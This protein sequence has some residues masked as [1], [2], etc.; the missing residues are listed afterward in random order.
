MWCGQILLWQDHHENAYSTSTSLA[1][2]MFIFQF[3]DTCNVRPSY[4][5]N[6]HAWVGVL[7]TFT[8]FY[9]MLEFILPQLLR[10]Y[11]FPLMWNI[12]FPRPCILSLNIV[13]HH[14]EI[15]ICS[16]NALPLKAVCPFLHFILRLVETLKQDVV[17]WEWMDEYL[18][19]HLTCLLLLTT[20]YS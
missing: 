20:F 7:L 17:N 3:N 16:F 19:L 2:S 1:G 6:M 4:V 15:P 14:Q 10:F 13:P 11:S 12:T 18:Y 8:H 5:V 9:N